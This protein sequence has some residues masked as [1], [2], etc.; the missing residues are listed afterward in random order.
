MRRASIRTI[1]LPWPMLDGKVTSMRITVHGPI[2][3][4]ASMKK[5]QD[6]GI[7]QQNRDKS[8]QHNTEYASHDQRNARQCGTKPF[9]GR[10]A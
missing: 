5:E 3:S 6:V 1:G 4:S 9:A 7:G 10:R 2:G 8:Y